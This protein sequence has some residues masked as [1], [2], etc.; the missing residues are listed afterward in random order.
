MMEGT[1]QDIPATQLTMVDAWLVTKGPSRPLVRQ[2]EVAVLSVSCSKSGAKYSGFLVH[3]GNQWMDYKAVLS[4][5]EFL[6]RDVIEAIEKF[7][8]WLDSKKYDR[9]MN[10]QLREAEK[11]YQ[12]MVDFVK[13]SR[14][15]DYE[16]AMK[17]LNK[18]L[19]AA[20]DTSDEANEVVA[21]CR[22][23]F[24]NKLEEYNGQEKEATEAEAAD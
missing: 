20:E 19:D 1:V 11:D 3:H 24:K 16:A 23:F 5:R 15:A 7:V 10:M 21:D 4:E 22:S 14:L 13:S 6:T 18:L 9:D 2:V 12:A 8:E 17:E